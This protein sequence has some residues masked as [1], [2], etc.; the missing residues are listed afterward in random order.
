M[1]LLTPGKSFDTLKKWLM[2][3]IFNSLNIWC[4]FRAAR[5][6]WAFPTESDTDWDTSC[7]ILKGYIISIILIFPQEFYEALFFIVIHFIHLWCEFNPF[8]LLLWLVIN[9]LAGFSQYK[10]IIPK[11]LLN[12]T[13]Y[14][15]LILFV[16][17]FIIEADQWKL[18]LM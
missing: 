12:L 14:F 7:Y 5:M 6:P 18:F 8:D 3:I 16:Y 13:C 10:W 17:I 4:S 1:F 9:E 11:T 15:M 2:A